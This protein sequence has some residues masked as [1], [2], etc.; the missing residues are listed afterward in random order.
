MADIPRI[1]PHDPKV[2]R[3]HNL[4][5]HLDLVPDDVEFQNRLAARFMLK[6]GLYSPGKKL[7]DLDAPVL[8]Q[9][10]LRDETTP[11]DAAI[12]AGNR[13]RN[14]TVATYDVGH[15]GPYTGEWFETFVAE[16]IAFLDTNLSA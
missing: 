2:A 8:V 6:V 1:D 4:P 7:A 11:P 15:F 5:R 16:Q 13:A 10:G 12:T 9:V 14:G 3:P